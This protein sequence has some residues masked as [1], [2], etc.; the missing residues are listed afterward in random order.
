M[1]KNTFCCS[2]FL[3]FLDIAAMKCIIMKVITFK[4]KVEHAFIQLLFL[5]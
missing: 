5:K 4:V 1:Y 2:D 3:T